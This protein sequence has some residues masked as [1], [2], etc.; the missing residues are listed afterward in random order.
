MISPV[1]GPDQAQGE[2]LV[3]AQLLVHLGP[4]GLARV[5]YRLVAVTVEALLELCVGRAVRQRPGE[6][7]KLSPGEE[8]RHRRVR[9]AD[10]TGDGAS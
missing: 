1:L 5:A 3:T 8:P 9:D 7:G 4:V 2:V 6:A 10:G